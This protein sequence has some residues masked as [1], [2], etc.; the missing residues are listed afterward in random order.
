MLDRGMYASVLFCTCAP[1]LRVYCGLAS[2]GNP[3]PTLCPT[4]TQ[5]TALLPPPCLPSLPQTQQDQFGLDHVTTSLL[6]SKST[7]SLLIHHLQKQPPHQIEQ[8]PRPDACKGIHALQPPPTPS[9]HSRLRSIS[10]RDQS[11]LHHMGNTEMSACM[12]VSTIYLEVY[13][14]GLFKVTVCKYL[15]SEARCSRIF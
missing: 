9:R 12:Q 11:P 6:V 7:S 2:V 14:N 5:L 13:E 10:E 15:R 3:E 1:R 4:H 8:Q